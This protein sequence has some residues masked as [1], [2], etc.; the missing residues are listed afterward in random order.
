[1]VPIED[2]VGAMAELVAEGKVGHLGLSE[3]S[4][5]TIRR[6]VAV[7]PITAV[8]TEWSLFTRDIET[9]VVPACR[10]LGV[11]IVPYSPLGR[12]LLTGAISTTA[13]MTVDDIRR[14]AQP[15]FQGDNLE[16]NLRLVEIVKTVAA[17]HGC[18]PG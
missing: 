11:G 9:E 10:E 14:R 6:A 1:D 2:T 15:R 3:A 5:Q 17:R 4:A 18:T 13:A 12:G 7:H 8:Q 16:H